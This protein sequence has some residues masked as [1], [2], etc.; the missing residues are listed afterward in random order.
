MFLKVIGLLIMSTAVMANTKVQM[1]TNLGDIEIEL[2]D[3]KAPETVKNFLKYVEAGS[4]KGTIFHRVMKDFMI[5]GGGFD[6]DMKKVSTKSPIK[7]EADNG[8]SNVNGTIAMARTNDPHSA[9]NQ[10]FINVTDNT[11]LN[12]RD[13]SPRGWGYAVFGKVTK[14]MTVI[15]KIKM[16]AVVPK[17]G[18]QHVPVEPVIIKDIKKL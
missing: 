8:E 9:T 10:F 3:K 18:H 15:N 13:K 4:Y 14:G 17:A 11:F 7:N 16:Q 5:Q 6:K 1:K 12:H 2:F